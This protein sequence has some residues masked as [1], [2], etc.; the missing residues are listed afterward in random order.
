MKEGADEE[1]FKYSGILQ[2]DD[3]YQQ[4]MKEKVQKEYFKRVRAVLKSKMN[5][6]NSINAINI[7]AVA[8]VWYR[9]GIIN[10]NKGDLDKIDQ[11]A[12]NLLNLHRGLHPCSSVDRLYIPR[13]QGVRWMLSVKNCVEL[14]RSNLYN[15]A[16]NSN[17]RLLTAAT[18]ELQL[19]TNIDEEN[20]EEQNNER[21]AAWKEK[22]LHGQ[23][24]RGTD[25]MQ[26]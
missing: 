26:D 22:V 25:W 8:T 15:Y 11:Q 9:A 17:K 21:Q 20:E 6:G 5:S 10:W 4:K 18:G 1:G 2:K 14:E 23:F 24:Q 19:K 13:T 12:R 16:A 7:W 3:I